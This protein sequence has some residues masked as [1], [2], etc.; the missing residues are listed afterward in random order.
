MYTQTTSTP[1]TNVTL[2]YYQTLSKKYATWKIDGNNLSVHL[3]QGLLWLLLDK[4]DNFANQNED[5]YNLSIKKIF[6]IN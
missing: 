5:F 2:I 3:L 1:C 6:N 4:R